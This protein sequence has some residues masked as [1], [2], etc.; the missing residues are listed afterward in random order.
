MAAKHS[1]WDF[2]SMFSAE[3]LKDRCKINQWD[4]LL[5]PATDCENEQNCTHL[6]QIVE[7]LFGFGSASLFPPG[8]LIQTLITSEG[9]VFS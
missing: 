7:R 2:S 8:F 9:H 6:P 1:L 4:S 3:H 5:C